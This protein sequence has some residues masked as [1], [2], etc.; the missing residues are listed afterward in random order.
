M[1]YGFGL[2]GMTASI[3]LCNINFIFSNFTYL[4]YV[5]VITKKL[6]LDPAFDDEIVENYIIISLISGFYCF[7]Q[8][9]NTEYNHRKSF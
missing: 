3:L 7:F 4:V 1:Y 9:K 8:V 6:K 5:I 2:F